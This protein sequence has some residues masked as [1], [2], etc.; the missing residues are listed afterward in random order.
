MRAL[1]CAVGQCTI[2]GTEVVMYILQKMEKFRLRGGAEDE[3]CSEEAR[4]EE[5]P[6]R[7]HFQQ[8]Y[9]PGKPDE[10][11]GGAV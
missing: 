9:A 10:Q 6:G 5:A 11:N 1:T 4:L 2:T 7:P 3:V 8:D